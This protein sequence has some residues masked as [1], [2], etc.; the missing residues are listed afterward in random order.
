MSDVLAAIQAYRSQGGSKPQRKFKLTYC[1]VRMPKQL[2]YL[3]KTPKEAAVKA[4]LEIFS[5]VKPGTS[6]IKFR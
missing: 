3:A 6:E 4:N 5:K 2:T 1:D